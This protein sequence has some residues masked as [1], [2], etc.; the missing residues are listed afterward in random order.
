MPGNFLDSLVKL[1]LDRGTAVTWY[2]GG[3]YPGEPVF[4]R[5]EG[6]AAEDDGVILSVVLDVRQAASFLLV[7]DAATFRE[8]ARAD[9]PHPIPFG[10]HG[11]YLAETAQPAPE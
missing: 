2:E 8:L 4:V 11:D 5:S 10:A 3:C 7:L 6:A 1:D 9:V